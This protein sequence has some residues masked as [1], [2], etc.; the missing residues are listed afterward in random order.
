MTDCLICLEAV[1][2]GDRAPDGCVPARLACRHGREMHEACLARWLVHGRG[3]PKCR[4]PGA[5]RLERSRGPRCG[6]RDAAREIAVAQLLM[7]CTRLLRAL[8][9]WLRRAARSLFPA[10]P[11]DP[12]PG[13]LGRYRL[14]DLRRLADHTGARPL[15]ARLKRPGQRLSVR[16]DFAEVLGRAIR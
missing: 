16:A 3:C 1:C 5:Q 2:A 11:R 10:A 13:D 4:A 9:A 14:A 15:M 7:L 8:L 6:G 12:D